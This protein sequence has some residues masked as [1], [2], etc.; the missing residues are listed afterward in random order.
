MNNDFETN[1]SSRKKPKDLSLFLI[2]AFLLFFIFIGGI[3]LISQINKKVNNSNPS[4]VRENDNKN[5]GTV[6]K[7]KDYAELGEFLEDKISSSSF[8]RNEMYALDMPR[9]EILNEGTW[10]ASSQNT[11]KSV[12]EDADY[13]TTNTQVQGVD[14]GDIVKTDGKYIYTVIKNEVIITEAFPIDNFK[15]I[16]RIKFSSLPS[17][18][19]LNGDKLIV[20]GQD[21]EIRTLED[22][23][24]IL[25]RRN[26]SYTFFKIY[27]LADKSNPV[28]ERSFD[29]EGNLSNSRMIGDYVYFVTSSYGTFYDEKFP[30]PMLIEDGEVLST[31]KTMANS[32]HPDVYYFDNPYHTYNFTTISALNLKD[33]SQKINSEIYLLDGQQNNMFVS[34][35]NIYITFNKY[36]SEDELMM[37]IFLEMMIP[38]LDQRSQE[39]IAKIQLTE[40]YILS[41]EEKKMKIMMI[42]EGFIKKLS[43]EEEVILEEE[44]KIRIKQK[45]QDISKELEKTIIHKIEINNGELEYQTSGEVTG[46]LLNQFS[47]DEQGGYFRIATT[48]NRSWSKF[49]DEKTKESYSNLY[50]LNEKMQVVGKV[51]G[52]A[53]GEKIYAVRFMQ[54]RAYLVTFKQVDPLFVIDLANPENP[55]VMGELKVP[56][57]SSYLHSYDENIL[58]GLGRETN[59]FGSVTGGVK[60]SLFDVSDITNPQEIDKY[61]LGN[62]R[63][64]S[65]A[66]NEHKAF[67]FS[68]DKNLLVIPITM[69][70]DIIAFEE[71]IIDDDVFRGKKLV[72]PSPKEDNFFSGFAVFEINEQGFEMKGLIKHSDSG[73]NNNYYRYNNV[74]RSL[75]IDDTLYTLSSKYLKANSLSSLEEVSNLKF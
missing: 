2:T 53:K 25:P 24:N 3:V 55:K 38:R 10:G 20:Y 57:Y 15:E 71:N 52:L 29:F 22:Y 59:E 56:G 75:Y 50:V 17:G 49:G 37:D 31:D 51:E 16:A 54:N 72:I 19:Y 4:I 65:I 66:I 62:S 30:I 5:Q 43:E 32:Y 67:L 68:K 36:V 58:I 64:N 34:E 60:L 35:N 1:S 61:V 44:L 42:L 48:R 74:N 41:S 46:V 12:P 13:S 7:F 73:E 69:M 28:L 39:Q 9:T 33:N 21:F 45:Y 11:P 27:N 40:N 70:D 23:K 8:G 14:E 6:K 26:N 63:S 18:L 47:M